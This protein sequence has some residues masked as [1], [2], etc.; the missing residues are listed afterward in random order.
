MAFILVKCLLYVSIVILQETSLVASQTISGEAPSH[1]RE[2]FTW[3]VDDGFANVIHGGEYAGDASYPAHWNDTGLLLLASGDRVVSTGNQQV[4]WMKV[5]GVAQT[6][7]ASIGVVANFGTMVTIATHGEEFSLVMRVLLTHHP[8]F[9][10]GLACVI[11]VVIS[12]ES[13]LSWK[14]NCVYIEYIICVFWHTEAT[15]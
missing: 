3:L 14:T 9:L 13:K 15:Y 2:Q 5:I 8:A 10:D 6:T 1:H 11:A 4:N 7:I 12:L